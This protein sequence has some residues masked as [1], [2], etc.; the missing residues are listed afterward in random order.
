LDPSKPVFSCRS[1]TTVPPLES[2]G[3]RLAARWPA[4]QAFRLVD[5]AIAAHVSSVERRGRLGKKYVGLTCGHGLVFDPP[6]HD[7]ELAFVE[8]D[9]SLAE[10]D[11]EASSEDQEE[12]VLLF[13]VMPH[14]L[15]LELRE[16][17]VLAVQLADDPRAPLFRELLE[18]LGEVHLLGLAV[19]HARLPNGPAIS[20]VEKRHRFG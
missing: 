5:S 18:F 4:L 6:R 17:D 3:S 10:V 12:L 2:A 15:A 7:E 1:P 13:V 20:G 11:G 9:G 14:E 8:V 19:A 16:L